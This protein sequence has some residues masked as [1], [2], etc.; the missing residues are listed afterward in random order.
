M[1]RV[2]A[3]RLVEMALTLLAVF[4]VTFLLIHS[5]PGGPFSSERKLTPEVERNMLA[6][7][8]LDD[9]LDVQYRRELTNVLRGDLGMSYRNADFS[10]NQMVAEGFRVSAALGILA[11]WFAILAGTSVGVLAAVRRGSAVDVGLTSLVTLGVAVPNFIVAGLA[12]MLFSFAGPRLPPAGW[13]SA[14]Q[15]ILPVFCLG[16][17]YAAY[18][19]RLTRTG[20]L[21]VLGRD[22]IRTA[23]AKGLSE[24]TV[25]LKH[26]LKGALLPVVSFLGPAAAGLLSGS[27]VVEKIFALPGLGSHFVDAVQ[28]RDYTVVMGMTLV[29]AVLLCSLNLIVDLSYSWFDP[30]IQAE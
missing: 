24:T 17:P 2:L 1:F 29:Y 6:R 14:W 13:G 7:Y 23:R 22:Y 26:A 5:V 4:T 25:V 15:L 18:I 8:H 30:R 16:L 27:V 12:I 9:P 3:R 19:A 10:V 20:M 28:Q 21:E 11:L